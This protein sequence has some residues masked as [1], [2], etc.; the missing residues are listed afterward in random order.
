MDNIMFQVENMQVQLNEYGQLLDNF[1]D[2]LLAH[3]ADRNNP[4]GVTKAQVGLGNVDNTSDKDKPVSTAT[5]AAL[6]TLQKTVYQNHIWTNVSV[7]PNIGYKGEAT[8]VTLNYSSGITGASGL[9]PSYKVKKNDTAVTLV[10]G[11]K[12]AITDNTTY[13]VT[14]TLGG[15]SKTASTAF[16]AYYPIYSFASGSNAVTT[17]PENAVKNP[18]RSTPVGATYNYSITSNAYLYLAFP[19]GMSINGA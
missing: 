1:G 15:V 16:K 11:G 8:E 18:V 6:S 12:E 14:G 3:V 2:D 10:S 4:H 7:T 5:Q 13:E 19:N 9:T 17:V